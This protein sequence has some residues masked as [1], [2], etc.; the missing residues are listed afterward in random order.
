M[1]VAEVAISVQPEAAPP[2]CRGLAWSMRVCMRR[3]EKRCA[4]ARGGAS[5]G[6]SCALRRTKKR[7]HASNTIGVVRRLAAHTR[8]SQASCVTSVKRR[9]AASGRVPMGFVRPEGLQPQ[10]VGV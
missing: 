4:T 9:A 8:G 3:K 10:P 1:H 5:S 6:S 7:T 2:L